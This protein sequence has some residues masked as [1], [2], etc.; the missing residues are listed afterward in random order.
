MMIYA[1]WTL[2]TLLILACFSDG[3]GSNLAGVAV[4]GGCFLLLVL[5]LLIAPVIKHTNQ[6]A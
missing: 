3:S 4:Q 6:A 2:L 1:Q 5:C